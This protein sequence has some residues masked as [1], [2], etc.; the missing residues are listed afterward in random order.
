MRNFR[1]VSFSLMLTALMVASFAAFAFTPVKT[2][3][4]L[5]TTS[6][7]FT[8]GSISNNV[9]VSQDRLNGGQMAVTTIGANTTNLAAWSTPLWLGNY[10][11]CTFVVSG[12]QASNVTAYNVGAS[13][14]NWLTLIPSPDGVNYVSNSAISLGPITPTYIGTNILWGTNLSITQLGAW[15]YWQL[16]WG[17]QGTNSLANALGQIFVRDPIGYVTTP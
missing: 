10:Q 11:T 9:H 13:C 8:S 16:T 15:P 12:N 17:V 7:L 3:Q 5:S 14:T 1:F 2:Q 4:A 6:P